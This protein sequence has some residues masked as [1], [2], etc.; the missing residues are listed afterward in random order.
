MVLHKPKQTTVP[1]HESQCTG[2]VFVAAG[3]GV[4]VVVPSIPDVSPAVPSSSP[5]PP[6]P[7]RLLLPLPP[8]P[9]PLI[10]M[11]RS[12]AAVSLDCMCG[13]LA[14]A[15]VG[16][17][18]SP[19]APFTVRLSV[20]SAPTFNRPVERNDVIK[21]QRARQHGWQQGYQRGTDGGSRAVQP[22]YVTGLSTSS[23]CPRFQLNVGRE[24]CVFIYIYI[25][26]TGQQAQAF[27]HLPLP[28]TLS[29]DC[30]IQQKPLPASYLLQ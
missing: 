23:D 22:R 8:M 25:Y 2:A 17:T 27:L 3:A 14:A 26:F 13:A 21:L 5:P 10:P 30:L 16:T 7:P 28:A 11:P 24:A 1:S 6:S 9:T 29:S 15:P 18:S 4:A 20:M 12:G 19:C